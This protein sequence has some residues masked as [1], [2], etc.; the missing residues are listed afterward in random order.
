MRFANMPILRLFKFMFLSSIKRLVFKR[1]RQQIVFLVVFF[2][3]KNFNKIE[4]FGPK[5][6]TNPFKKMRIL[7]VFKTDV[8]M[9]QAGLFWYKTS[10]IVFL[11]F[12]FTI[13]YMWIKGVTRVD[14]G[15]QRVTRGDRGLQGVVTSLVHW[16]FSNSP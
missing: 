6:W 12:I 14:R 5:P 2:I 3:K 9:V 7:W 15:L 13:Y 16:L 8:F 11:R 1:H 10:K 4:N